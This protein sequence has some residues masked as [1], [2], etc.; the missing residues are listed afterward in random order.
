MTYEI[1][2]GSNVEILTTSFRLNDEQWHS[3]ELNRTGLKILLSIDGSQAYSKDLGGPYLT[4]EYLLDD[5]FA[6]GVPGLA[7]MGYDGCLQDIRFNLNPLPVTGSNTFASVAFIGGEP[8]FECQVG[9]CY[10]NPCSTGNCSEQED[11]TYLCTCPNGQSQLTSCDSSN[12]PF[13]PFAVAIALGL[14]IVILLFTLLVGVAVIRRKIKAERKYNLNIEPPPKVVPRYEIHSNVYTYDDEG[15]GEEDTNIDNGPIAD[16][17]VTSLSYS[18]T[19]RTTPSPSITSI[20]K[21]KLL[22]QMSVHSAS[23]NYPRANT[24]DIDAFIEDRVNTANKDLT[25]TDS[26]KQFKDEG[27]GSLNGSLSTISSDLDP[28][29]YTILR[30]HQAGVEFQGIADLL[31]PVLGNNSDC[32]SDSG[33]ENL[34]ISTRTTQ[35][36]K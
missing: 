1:N 28:E 7:T 12:V 6:A 15:G 13:G 2:L 10:P 35:H 30:L 11:N 22:E 36:L 8:E 33:S 3:I 4:L 9:P 31:E 20:D 17:S 14:L 27:L 19:E 34:H 32:E 29:P 25:G 5:I 24:P 21:L 16:V 18:P 26:V 23:P